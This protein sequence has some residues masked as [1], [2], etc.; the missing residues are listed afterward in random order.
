MAQVMRERRYADDNP[1]ADASNTIARVVYTIGGIVTGLLAIR[2]MLVLF[3][4]NPNNAFANIIYDLSRP[5]V[6]PF[7]GLFNYDGQVGTAGRFEFETLIAIVVYG[8]VAW[9]L[10]RLFSSRNTNYSDY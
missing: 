9:V 5:I 2:F 4:A 10:V 3:G 8:L 1:I 6:S 7:F